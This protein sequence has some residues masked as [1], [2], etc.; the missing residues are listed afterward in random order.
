MPTIV[1]GPQGLDMTN[2]DLSV[3]FDGTIARATS[4]TYQLSLPDGELVTFTGIGFTYNS[5]GIPTGGTVT[6]LSDSYLGQSV[7]QA[8]GFSV[9]AT[10][11]VSWAYNGQTLQALQTVLGGSDTIIASDTGNLLYGFGGDDSIVGGA[12]ADYLDAGTGGNT[13]FGGAGADTVIAL[14]SAGSNSLLAG[15]GNDIVYGGSGFDAVNGNKGDDTVIGRST[16][17]DWLLG[18]QGQDSIDAT[19]SIGHNIIN[20]NLGN[21]TVHGGSGG[22]SLR[23]GQG[24]DV[25][26]G[27]A[28]ADWIT[29][30]LGSNTLTGGQGSDTFHASAGTSVV[31]DFAVSQGDRVEVDHGVTYQTSQ[32]G[33]DAHIDFSNGGHLVLQNVQLSALTGGWIVTT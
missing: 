25:I 21:D 1:A 17:G 28:G 10:S 32:S 16:V 9:P 31:T 2:L 27:G 14:N 6:G 18:G 30:D 23:G 26:V 7:Y 13:V 12:G 8:S 24:D 3:L 22:D 19:A 15:D 29:G 11:F 4:T 5:S 20:G 33:A